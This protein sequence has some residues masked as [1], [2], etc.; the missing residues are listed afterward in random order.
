M[1]QTEEISRAASTR[2]L[3]QRVIPTFLVSFL[4]TILV[5]MYFFAPLGRTTAG[6]V[7]DP[8]TPEF[9]QWGSIVTTLSFL[10]GYLS[11]PLIHVRRLIARKVNKKM[12]FGSA[13][14]L[15]SLGLMLI[16]IYLGPGGSG[17][18]VYSTWNLYMIG[19]V[20]NGMRADW[21]W[22]PYTSFRI[23]RITALESGLF[24]VSFILAVLSQLPMVTYLAPVL[25]T[26]GDWIGS[27]PTTASMR[28]GLACS[29]VSSIVLF[30]RSL[31]GREPGLIEVEAL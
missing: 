3:Y 18:V 13:V 7:I 26:A 19:F 25:G 17:G 28:A 1:T 27:I 21:A 24:V 31:V 29:G 4:A 16:I 2:R 6:K 14:S 10:F 30:V 12:L 9:T 11:I 23:M 8:I 15:I 5:I 22:H 20:N